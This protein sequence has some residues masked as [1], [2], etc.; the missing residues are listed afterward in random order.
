MMGD[1]RMADH[2]VLP[3]HLDHL[4]RVTSHEEFLEVVTS[5]NFGQAGYE[6]SA[7]F[8]AGSLVVTGGEAHRA[9]LRIEK[10]LFRRETLQ[11]YETEVLIPSIR[12]QLDGGHADADGRAHD[13]LVPLARRILTQIAARVIGFDD[14]DTPER[15]DRLASFTGPLAQ[16]SRLKFATGDQEALRL[17]YLGLKAE[18]IAEFVG[19]AVQRREALVADAGA[20]RISEDDLPRDLITTMLAH[21][22][23]GWDGDLINREAILYLVGATLTTAQAVP[24]ALY[25]IL[26][27]AEQN[28]DRADLIRD[29]KFVRHAAYESMRMHAS[30]PTHM[31]KA[32]VDVT[33][34]SGRTFAA[35]T[36]VAVMGGATGYDESVFGSNVEEFDPFRALLDPGVKRYGATFLYGEHKCIGAHLAAGML[37]TRGRDNGT[38]GMVIRILT[39][40]IERDVALVS[41]QPPQQDEA[42]YA[43]FYVSFPITYRK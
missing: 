25:H 22:D 20:G 5:R 1:D 13:D 32:L 26:E 33:L 28:P 18:Y 36:E 23:P 6:G 3:P 30:S 29:L 43:D 31:R 19:P 2:S 4:P 37:A 9:R 11:H 7:D 12:R 27:W 14:V 17:E 40:L 8:L 15:I 38:Q 24:H 21:R 16:A 41:G 34:Q 35:G 42:T 39:A 10:E